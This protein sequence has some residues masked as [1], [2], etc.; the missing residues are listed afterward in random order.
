VSDLT[1]IKQ[2][3]QAMWSSG[4]FSK[5]AVTSTIVGELLCEAVDVHFDERV[6]DV[7]CGNGNSALAA[8]RR[9]ARV[10]GVDYVPALLAHARR[11][12]EVEGFEG[13]FMEGDAEALP[14]PDAGFDVVVSTFGV[15]FAPDHERAAKELLRACRPGGRIGLACWTPEGACGEMFRIGARY[16][17]PPPGLKPA[18][19]WGTEAH[20][21]ALFG[22]DA[23]ELR[24]TRRSFH[25]RYRSPEHWLEY[26][27]TWF[28]P[29]K[30]A[31]DSLPPERAEAYAA[32]LLDLCRRY[33][34]AKDGTLSAP[35][36]YLEV[37]ALRA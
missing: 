36:E 15:M 21:R 37:V 5:V 31:F 14:V 7:A 33:N 17:A 20:L 11:R 2:A 4:D 32:D 28:G 18:T 24:A 1:Q 6:L 30:R 22:D 23:A 13:T 35:G 9:F 16:L 34:T 3:Q 8:A 12:F 29:T 26:F 27:R 10:T 25:M 19:L